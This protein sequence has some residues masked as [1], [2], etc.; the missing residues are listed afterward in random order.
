MLSRKPLDKRG[1]PKRAL[2]APSKQ[3]DSPNIMCVAYSTLDKTIQE[4][5]KWLNTLPKFN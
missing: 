3:E 5:V 4:Q 2:A 1:R